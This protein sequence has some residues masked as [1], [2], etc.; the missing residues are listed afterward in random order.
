M[1]PVLAAAAAAI[2]TAA[3]GWKPLSEYFLKKG[4]TFAAADEEKRLPAIGGVVFT[5]AFLAAVV[6]GLLTA[7]AAGMVLWNLSAAAAGAVFAPALGFLFALDD[8]LLVRRRYDSGMPFLQQ[9][10]PV[11]LLEASTLAVLGSSGL[12]STRMDLPFFGV[13]ECSVFYYPLVFLLMNVTVLSGR[14]VC[15]KKGFAGPYLC[16]SAAGLLIGAAVLSASSAM[17]LA[18]ALAAAGAL[19]WI[20]EAAGKTSV[21]KMALM[22]GIGGLIAVTLTVDFPLLMLFFLPVPLLAGTC[23]SFMGEATAERGLNKKT[24]SSFLQGIYWILAAVMGLC[25]AIAMA[26]L[27]R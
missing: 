7:S 13:A 22:T 14:R 24:G 12:L 19:L 18:A 2:L 10:L 15:H 20:L 5:A 21:T 17:I 8:D 25:S 26:M 16:G 23:S 4:Y 11:C 3:V 1:M 6:T 9:M 27:T